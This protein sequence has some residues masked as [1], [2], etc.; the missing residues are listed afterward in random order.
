MRDC[1]PISTWYG[2]HR[3]EERYNYIGSSRR[4]YERAVDFFGEDNMYEELFIAFARFEENQK[5]V[6]RLM[7][8]WDICGINCWQSE[9]PL[10]ATNERA[11]R[12]CTFEA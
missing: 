6:S 9:T 4:I 2:V 8:T 11:P 7:R 5:E 12:K 3:F 10:L 1:S